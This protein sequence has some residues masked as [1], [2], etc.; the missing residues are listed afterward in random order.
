MYVFAC[1]CACV[2]EKESS[3]NISTILCS[4]EMVVKI[5]QVITVDVNFKLS[6]TRGK[7]TPSGNE[8]EN[9]AN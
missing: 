2:C 8:N 1:V 6:A 3:E 4:Q 9:I 7:G 5:L